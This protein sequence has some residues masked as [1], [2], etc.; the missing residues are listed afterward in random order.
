MTTVKPYGG[1]K[2]ANFVQTVTIAI[3]A[4]VSDAIDFR[5]VAGAQVIIPA[6]F[7]GDI[8]FKV[9]DTEDG[10]FVILLDEDGAIVEIDVTAA[11][12]QFFPP[13]VF[14]AQYVKL[15]SQNAGS[16]Q[17]QSAA[18]SLVVMAKA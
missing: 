2:R 7:Q 17:N 14:P 15:W 18:R 4:N 5:Q 1:A 16:D 13:K 6:S 9:C 12:A 11:R 8:G 10:A 3:D